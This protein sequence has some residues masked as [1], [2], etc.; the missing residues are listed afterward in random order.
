MPPRITPIAV[1]AAAATP[2]TAAA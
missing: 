2:M 1:A